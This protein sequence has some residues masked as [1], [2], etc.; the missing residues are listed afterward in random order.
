MFDGEFQVARHPR[1]QARGLGMIAHYSSVFLGKPGERAVRVDTQRGHPHHPDQLQ[2]RR[3]RHLSADGVDGLGVV[4]V[5]TAAL[6][7]AVE[8]QLYIDV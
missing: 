1:R 3:V 5:D 6:G 2:P 8:A 7:V 4:D